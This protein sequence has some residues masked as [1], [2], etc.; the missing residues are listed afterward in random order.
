MSVANSLF[1]IH[2]LLYNYYFWENLN[3]KLTPIFSNNY[4]V[5]LKVN[6]KLAKAY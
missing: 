6:L 2:L 4:S 3:K 5:K 1:S